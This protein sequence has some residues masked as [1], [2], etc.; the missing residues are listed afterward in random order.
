VKLEEPVPSSK[1]GSGYWERGFGEL[2]Y[3][4][5]YSSLL[6]ITIFD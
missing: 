5:S 2:P 1:V 6:T 3:S 4:E